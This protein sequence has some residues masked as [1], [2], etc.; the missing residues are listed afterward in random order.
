MEPPRQTSTRIDVITTTGECATRTASMAAF[1]F[2]A[3]AGESQKPLC[4]GVET[5]SAGS[6]KRKQ[7]VR[8]LITR[9]LLSNHIFGNRR[10][11]IRARANSKPR[12]RRMADGMMSM[13][14]PESA[15][16]PNPRRA[17]GHGQD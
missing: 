8:A 11:A 3:A 7:P 6:R 13:K 15:R 9:E 17:S 2:H 14:N 1:G 16:C 10:A 4:S 5:L 12:R